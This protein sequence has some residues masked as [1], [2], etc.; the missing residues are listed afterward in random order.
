MFV[1]APR[2]SG[3]S[4]LHGESKRGGCPGAVTSFCCSRSGPVISNTP[5]RPPN[6]QTHTHKHTPF[7]NLLDSSDKLHRVSQAAHCTLSRLLCSPI[8]DF[9]FSA[10][11]T[12]FSKE[13][14]SRLSKERPFDKLTALLC[15]DRHFH[16]LLSKCKY[17]CQR[18]L[19]P[20]VLLQDEVLDEAA[21]ESCVSSV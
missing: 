2:S 7:P 1:F 6:T 18:R 14:E 19:L 21:R 12:A 3:A 13:E 9:F 17:S 11:V 15:T 10:F 4:P 16:S 20:S 8:P 5:L